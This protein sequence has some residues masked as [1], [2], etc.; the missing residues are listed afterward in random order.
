MCKLPLNE[1]NIVN[2]RL[3]ADLWQHDRLPTSCYYRFCGDDAIAAFE[4]IIIKTV[5][6][7]QQPLLFG[8]V[9]RRQWAN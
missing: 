2:V 1:L 8:A 6:V 3:I 9:I 4:C 5:Q 7:L